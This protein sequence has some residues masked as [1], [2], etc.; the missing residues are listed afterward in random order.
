MTDPT[1]TGSR[2]AEH[3]AINLGHDVSAKGVES[4]LAAYGFV[5]CALPEIDL[6]AVDTAT[7]WLGRRLRGPLLISC[8]TGGVPEAARVNAILAEAAESSRVALGLGSARALLENPA[9]PGFDVRHLAPSVPLLA[10]LGAVQLNCGVGLDDCRRLVALLEADALVLH[11]NPLQE[12]LQVE[13]DTRFSG[14]L[15]RIAAVAR[16]LE[17]PVVVKEVGW[18]IDAGLVRALIDAGVS[19][20]D[21]A[22]AGGTSWSEVERHRLTGRRAQV[23]GAFAGWGIPTADAILAARAAAPEAVLIASGGVQ[24]G[25]DAAVAVALG[26]DLVGAAGPVLRAAQGGVGSTVELLE[27]WLDVLRIA[28]FCVGATDLG[29]LRATPRLVRDGV[30]VARPTARR[31]TAVRVVRAR[32]AAAAQR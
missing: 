7:T 5:H 29:A 10:N 14:L 12:A 3:L 9:A 1:R 2:K 18:G 24:R 30:R 8:M 6:A 4:G 11:L 15:A 20:V 19:A 31:G 22:G 13:G 23:A 21:I 28:M 27:E 32:R 16:G 17:V 25:M 26:A